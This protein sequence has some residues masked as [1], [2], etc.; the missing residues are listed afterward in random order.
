[1]LRKYNAA[2]VVVHLYNSDQPAWYALARALRPA[3]CSMSRLDK[4]LELA[5]RAVACDAG[6]DIPSARDAYNAACD[7]LEHAIEA[8][9]LTT[10]RQRLVVIHG[11][12]LERV[13]LLDSLLRD[14]AIDTRVFEAPCA[15]GISQTDAVQTGCTDAA[16]SLARICEDRD[17]LRDAPTPM[18]MHERHDTDD[19]LSKMSND[20]TL[21]SPIVTLQPSSTD[22]RT[23][24]P[25]PAHLAQLRRAIALDRGSQHAASLGYVS[26][27]PA[28]WTV[29]ACKIK[30]EG[31]KTICCDL[32]SDAIA[33]LLAIPYRNET[34]LA[35]FGC[36]LQVAAIQCEQ[37]FT[38]R[39]GITEPEQSRSRSAQPPGISTR[40]RLLR[41]VGANQGASGGTVATSLSHLQ[42]RQSFDRLLQ[43]ILN[44]GQLLPF[45]RLSRHSHKAD[46]ALPSWPKTNALSRAIERV[47]GTFREL[48]LPAFMKDL[49]T[50][51]VYTIRSAPC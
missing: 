27:P 23:R 12:Y 8:A 43:Q 50:L 26:V 2:R 11:S 19:S 32:L 13:R 30:G 10:E 48:L 25:L 22:E 17:D 34:M 37:Y 39:F 28:A 31:E 4:A 1:M 5:Q 33:K 51:L 21:H 16:A 46:E 24:E 45:A 42:Y 49:K 36:E 35:R 20:S 9:V 7:L 44:L 47:H 38:R 29:T 6:D 40:A 15:D 18:A 41:L 3:R 14:R